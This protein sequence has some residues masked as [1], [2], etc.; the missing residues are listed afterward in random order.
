MEVTAVS[1]QPTLAEQIFEA[2]LTELGDRKGFDGWWYGIPT[3]LQGEIRQ[4]CIAAID[5]QLDND[6]PD[7]GEIYGYPS[8]RGY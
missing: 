1:K 5:T 4:E 2:V 8:E 7:E 6:R 3:A